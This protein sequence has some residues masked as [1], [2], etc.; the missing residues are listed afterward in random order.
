[1]RTFLL[2]VITF[3]TLSC[4]R[5]LLTDE[6]ERTEK[7]E[8]YESFSNLSFYDI[9]EIELKTDSVFSVKKANLK[10]KVNQSII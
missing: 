3:S 9:F 8:I 1:M 10:L 7:L 6:R 4:E 5:I 2:L